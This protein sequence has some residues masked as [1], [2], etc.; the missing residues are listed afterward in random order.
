MP[1]TDVQSMH[2]GKKIRVKDSA[3]ASQLQEVASGKHCFEIVSSSAKII[4]QIN[5]HNFNA[6]QTAKA[7][8]KQTLK[9]VPSIGLGKA[10]DSSKD[11]KGHQKR[12]CEIAP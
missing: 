8:P 1:Q 11:S 6:A 3:A 4:Q 5:K 10:L 7:E 2:K 12:F 9:P